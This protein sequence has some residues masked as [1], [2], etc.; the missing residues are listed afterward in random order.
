MMAQCDVRAAQCGKK[1]AE[2]VAG[3]AEHLVLIAQ[4]DVRVTECGRKL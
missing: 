1:L 4:L 3:S 2:P